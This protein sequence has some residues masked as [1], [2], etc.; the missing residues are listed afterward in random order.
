MISHITQWIP[1]ASG[2]SNWYRLS[3]NKIALI[4]IMMFSFLYLTGQAKSQAINIK[5]KNTDF[6]QAISQIKQVTDLD[7]FYVK[8]HLKGTSPVTLNLKNASSSELLEQLL[9]DQ[10]LTYEIKEG[11]IVLKK[12]KSAPP[13]VIQQE[14]TSVSGTVYDSNGVAIPSATVTIKGTRQGTSSDSNGRFTLKAT[15]GDIIIVSLMGYQP[16]EIEYKGQASLEVYLTS[17]PSTLDEVVVIGYGSIKKRNLTGAVSQINSDD[18]HT[19]VASSFQQV[20]QGKAAGMEV[21]QPT[22]QPGAAVSVKIRSNPSFANA[23]VL[24]VIDGVPVNDNAGNLAL[25][26]GGVGGR[27]EQAGVNKSPM[28]FINPND[29]ES[30]EVLKDAS[31]ASIYGARAG[32]GV[33]LITTKKGKEG[34]ASLQYS[35]NYGVQNSD[36]MYPVFGVREYMEQRNLLRLEKWYRDNKVAPWYG[37]NN[38]SDIITPYVPVYT[39]NEI[40]NIKLNGKGATDAIKRGGYTQQHNLSLSGGNNTTTYFVS[41]NYFDQKGVIIATDYERYNGRVNLDHQFSEKIKLGTNIIVSNSK[42]NNTITGGTLENGGIVTSAIYWAPTVPLQDENG[43]YPLS[44]YYPNIPNPLSY[45]TN[46]DLTNSKRVLT[47]AYGEWQILND[48]QAKA[49]FSYDQS[50]SKRSSYFSRDFHYGAQVGGAANISE[51]DH[52]T[53]LFEYTL[54]YNTDFNEKHVLNAMAGYSYQ[55][56]IWSNFGAGHQNFLSDDLLYY[57]LAAGQAGRPFVN[58]GKSENIWASYFG[59]A[60]YTYNGNITLQASIRRDGASVFADNKKWG[61]FPGFSAGWIISDEHWMPTEGPISF[62]KLRAGYGETGNSD[63]GSAALAEYSARSAYFGENAV[64]T[65]LE[66]TRAANPNLTWETA[67]EFNVGL[68]FGLFNQRVSAS[69]DYFN[70]TIRNLI[71]F[72]PYPSGFIISGVYSNAGKTRSTGYDINLETKNLISS[73]VDGFS[74]STSI[75]FSH[76]LNYWVQRSP[77]ALRTL[78]KYEVATGKDALFSPIFGYRAQG[79]FTGRYGEAPDHMPNMLPGGIILKDIRSYDNDG[80]LAGPDGKI[81]EADRTYIGN[82]DPKFN[83]GIGNTFRYKGFDLHVFLSGMKLKKWSP[84]EGGRVYELNMDRYG[85]N[86]MP[87]SR[88]RWHVNNIGGNLPTALYDEN[89]SSFQN[90]SDYWL[91]NATFLRARNITLGYTLPE[92][93]LGKQGVFS[94][95]RLSF[96][97]QNLFTITKYPGLDPELD[98]GNFYPLVKSFVFGLNANF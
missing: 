3:E 63:F 10:P 43:K 5:L 79:L 54:N 29:I 90:G 31:A 50:Y 85:F 82:S 81:T 70:K 18:L 39:Q 8:S 28:N 60:I 1:G 91:L 97:A 17:T 64:R 36:K 89:Y 38:E 15:I 98:A 20:L 37:T 44:P 33:I 41:G 61:M 14:Q 40:D 77:E 76:Y 49:S 2:L 73:D 11:V 48:L 94:N 6:E 92:K 12:K 45:R 32:A 83:F 27:Y 52:Q 22:G 26:S 42:A 55:Q 84:L 68:D 78:A 71:A 74:W 80:N 62:L 66:L 58:S 34:K 69:V 7:F 93:A 57:D 9:K 75:N 13:A 25:G 51:G 47:A 35:G 56:T 96:D 19:G 46:T 67:G 87:V 23:G 65:G 53:K 59:R 72:V 16:K 95:L 86:A 4:C 21:S 88:N 24:Y 30:I